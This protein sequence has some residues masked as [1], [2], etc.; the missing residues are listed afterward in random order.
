VCVCVCVC[1]MFMS[2]RQGICVEVRGQLVKISSSLPL[3]GSSGLAAG[4]LTSE[5]SHCR[6][7]VSCISQQASK[8]LWSR[9]WP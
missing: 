2:V 5:P 9:G 8:L 3:C 6:E 1:V 7:K 4:D